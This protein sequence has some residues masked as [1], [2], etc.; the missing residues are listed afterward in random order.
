M[1]VDSVWRDVDGAAT[2]GK[3]RPWVFL[4][5]ILSRPVVLLGW[6]LAS[7]PLTWS[8]VTDRHQVG[9][10]GVAAW[11]ASAAGAGMLTLLK[12]KLSWFALTL[13]CRRSTVVFFLVD[14]FINWQTSEGAESSEAWLKSPEITMKASGC[15]FCILVI[16]MWTMSS[17]EITGR[18][19]GSGSP[20]SSVGDTTLIERVINY[21]Q[22]IIHF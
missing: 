3:H 2:A 19:R 20:L 21:W 13:A 15:C 10:H 14:Q 16:V 17:A 1:F 7:C 11:Q 5:H 6:R 18:T 12:K 4:W 8:K 9:G 22:L